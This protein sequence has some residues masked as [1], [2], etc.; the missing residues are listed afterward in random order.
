MYVTHVVLGL[1]MTE[2]GK[3]FGRDRTTVMHACH[4]VEDLR[5]DDDF[6][7][8]IARAEHIVTAAFR[9]RMPV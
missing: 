7:Q 6:D 8:I 4:L 1:S 3:G 5:D 2:I 9:G